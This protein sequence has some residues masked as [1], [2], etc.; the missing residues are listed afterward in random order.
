MVHLRMTASAFEQSASNMTGSLPLSLF[1][2]P[3]SLGFPPPS[4]HPPLGA[5][6]GFPEFPN[7]LGSGSSSGDPLP[8]WEKVLTPSVVMACTGLVRV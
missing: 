6:K 2:W 7:H 3:W 5:L 1:L 8:L 4:P